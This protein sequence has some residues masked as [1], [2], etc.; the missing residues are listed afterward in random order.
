M[1]I[2]D[3]I[4]T[5]VRMIYLLIIIAAFVAFVYKKAHMLAFVGIVATVI[6]AAVTMAY[7]KKEDGAL[8]PSLPSNSWEE[9][10]DGGESEPDSTGGLEEGE[11]EPDST[12][13]LEGGETNPGSTGEG[14]ERRETE[15]SLFN[16]EPYTFTPESMLGDYPFF[17]EYNVNDIFGNS[18]T[19]AYS[20]FMT[21]EEGERSMTFDL[22]KKYD[23]FAFTLAILESGK[24]KKGE[25]AVYIYADGITILEREHITSS[26]RTE[27]ITLSVS[28]VNDLTIEMYSGNYT[29]LMCEPVLLKK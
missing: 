3:K 16:L 14:L 10:L 4:P 13:E 5:V 20:A 7:E 21:M 23:T 28:N 29:I 26:Y 9:E 15:V 8:P 19:R 17:T 2:W 1:L 18:Y 6:I 22:G 27:P 11:S 24:G 25:G 12:G